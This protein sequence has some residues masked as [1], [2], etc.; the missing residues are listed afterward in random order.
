[1]TSASSG[2]AASFADSDGFSTPHLMRSRDRPSGSKSRPW[3]YKDRHI[4]RR[5]PR[6]GEH[7][8]A[9]AKPRGTH[10]CRWFFLTQFNGNVTPKLGCRRARRRLH[11]DLPRSAETNLPWVTG[12]CRCSP[13]STRNLSGTCVLHEGLRDAVLGVMGTDRFR[14]RSRAGRQNSFGS[15]IKT[16]GS[17]SW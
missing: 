7:D 11:R 17:S 13:R 9:M 16:S 5:N 8:K 15:M 2:A 10:N 1:L 12:F 6:L 14:R 3:D 4:C